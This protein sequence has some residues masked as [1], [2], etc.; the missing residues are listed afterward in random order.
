MAIEKVF[1]L[2][3]QAPEALDFLLDDTALIDREGG[4]AQRKLRLRSGMRQNCLRYLTSLSDI[5]GCT[6]RIE[7]AVRD[8]VK[9]QTHSRFLGIR[10][11]VR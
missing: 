9:A 5:G 7:D 10:G 4:D 6:A 1:R 2:R 3:I 11:L 8:M